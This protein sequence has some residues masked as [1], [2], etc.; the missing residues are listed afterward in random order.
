M[1]EHFSLQ[2]VFPELAA[3][4]ALAS[5]RCSF[6]TVLG[7]SGSLLLA[8]CVYIGMST[9]PPLLEAERKCDKHGKNDVHDAGAD[10]GGPKSRSTPAACHRAIVWGVNTGEA[11]STARIRVVVKDAPNDVELCGFALGGG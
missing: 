1:T 8:H 5:M 7:V 3:P 4:I 2:D 11:D 9:F 6:D 10:V